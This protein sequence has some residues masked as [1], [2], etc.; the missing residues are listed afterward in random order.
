MASFLNIVIKG[1][2]ICFDGEDLRAL[3]YMVKGVCDVFGIS[4]SGY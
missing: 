3:G 1:L 2:V 4:R